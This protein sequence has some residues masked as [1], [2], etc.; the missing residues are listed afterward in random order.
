MG[1]PLERIV[2]WIKSLR[3]TKFPQISRCCLLLFNNIATPSP[4]LLINH[5]HFNSSKEPYKVNNTCTILRK[6]K[7]NKCKTFKKAWAFKPTKSNNYSFNDSIYV[8]ISEN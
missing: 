2:A 5:Y 7:R 3:L 6:L 8:T 4:P 1:S